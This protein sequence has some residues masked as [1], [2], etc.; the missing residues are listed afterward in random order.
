[1]HAHR[2]TTRTSGAQTGRL[3]QQAG[4]PR[5]KRRLGRIVVGGFAAP[6]TGGGR[7]QSSNLYRN[8]GQVGARDVG[9]D[10]RLCA[11]IILRAMRGRRR[12]C[13][14]RTGRL[15]GDVLWTGRLIAGRCGDCSKCSR[16]FGDTQSH[17]GQR[18]AGNQDQRKRSHQAT[19][20]AARPALRMRVS[21]EHGDGSI[22]C[23]GQHTLD[24]GQRRPVDDR[25]P[26]SRPRS[27]S[28]RGCRRTVRARTGLCRLPSAS[29]VAWHP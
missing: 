16:R 13:R 18:I 4:K 29:L 3:E 20:R 10:T 12:I 9:A 21:V 15:I 1:M 14:Q 26:T 25:P 24:A 6:F 27:A 17:G 19:G 2:R 23:H 5:V 22:R 11:G 7:D 28:R 8:D